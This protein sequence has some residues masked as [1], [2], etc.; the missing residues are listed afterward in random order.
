MFAHIKFAH[1]TSYIAKAFKLSYSESK[2]KHIQQKVLCSKQ[3]TE[4]VDTKA[5]LS[6]SRS[7]PLNDKCKNADS[8]IP[9]SL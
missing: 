6:C 8:A 4:C 9:G 7:T 3:M 1:K 2:Q 5:R